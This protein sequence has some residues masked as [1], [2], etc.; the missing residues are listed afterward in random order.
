D[1]ISKYNTNDSSPSWLDY[2]P[3]LLIDP[4]RCVGKCSRSQIT[5]GTPFSTVV[6][7]DPSKHDVT[8]H[9][10]K[11]ISTG[12]QIFVGEGVSNFIAEYIDASTS[13]SPS[14][15]PGMAAGATTVGV[16]DNGNHITYRYN[17]VHDTFGECFYIGGSGPDPGNGVGY[18]VQN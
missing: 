15:G 4:K 1:G 8:I 18:S 5:A 3:T 16:R 13:G 2:N 10:F 11:L 14:I 7:S 9:G 12:G 6:A 17:Y